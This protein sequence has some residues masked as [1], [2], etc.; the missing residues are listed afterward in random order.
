MNT[1][2]SQLWLDKIHQLPELAAPFNLL[3]VC[4]GHERSI[5]HAGLRGVLPKG[6]NLIP[7][8]GCPVCVCPEADIALAI[9]IAMQANVVLLAFGDLLRVPINR[10]NP[11][12]LLPKSVKSLS[13]AK[14]AG[15]DIQPIASPL[16]A[17]KIAAQQPNKTVVFFAAGFE[18]T[19]A[20]VAALLTEFFSHSLPRNLVF[21]I[22]G[23]KTWP[24]VRKLLADAESAPIHGLIAPGHVATVMGAHEWQFI[25]DEFKIPSAIAGFESESLLRAF[26]SILQQSIS[27]KPQLEN[28]Y[29][30]AVKTQGNLHAQ[31]L[32]DRCFKVASSQWR[33]IGSINNSGFTL[34]PALAELDARNHYADISLAIHEAYSQNTMPKNCKCAEVVMAKC[35]PNQCPLYG[36]SCSP[37]Q[38]LGP[39]MVSDEGAC[40]IWWSA[41]HE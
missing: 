14:V 19:M 8:P 35:L 24:A 30:Q 21:L 36:T 4:G 9:A 34:V 1:S 40:R 15:A 6:L 25:P 27:H 33:G 2:G 31:T 41:G 20:P 17:K 13:Q 28:C 12:E 22:S 10:A 3:N 38:P 26:H 23:R 32:L 16:E 7:G 37:R 18:T 39:C 5:T 11:C 29:P